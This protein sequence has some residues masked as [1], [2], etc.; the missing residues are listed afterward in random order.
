MPEVHHAT[1][2]PQDDGLRLDRWF[3]EHYPGLPHGR[4]ERLLRTGQVRIDGKRVRAN[5]RVAAG[6][7][8]RIPPLP[9][10]ADDR[11]A[12]RAPRTVSAKAARLAGDLVDRVLYRDDSV[13]V[14]DKPAGLAVQGGSGTTVHL[15]G[16]LAALTFEA[17][18]P[19]RLV[20]RLDRD[21][22]GVL[23]LARTR[24]AARA[25]TAA[26]RSKDTRKLYWAAV[27]GRPT[28]AEGRI[29]LPLGKHSGAD[30]RD[31]MAPA[32]HPHDDG[33]RGSKVGQPA[34][35][36]Y[37]TIDHMHKA[38]AWLALLPLTG[39]THQLRVHC[40]ALGTPILGDGKYG[41]QGAFLSGIETDRQVHLHARRI[42]LPH[43][44]PGR[45]AID[46]SADPPPHMVRSWRLLGFADADGSAGAFF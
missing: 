34:V 13:L 14:L 7:T 29:D 9:D 45:P 42:R 38:A 4:L 28:P 20:H 41:G 5:A 35:T 18:E 25:L 33:T 3:R 27:V 31:R 30:G 12:P 2:A 6:Q 23:V 37:R 8:V 40:A 10:P 16:L 46:V 39:R 26:F 1:V 43:P 15:D 19:P 21:T 32:G 22:S 44:E 36:L 24:A 17:T 11:E